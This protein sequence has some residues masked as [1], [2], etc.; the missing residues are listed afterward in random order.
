MY[1]IL[2]LFTLSSYASVY[3]VTGNT[4]EFSSPAF[5]LS[6]LVKEYASAQK[7]NVVFDSDFR[8]TKFTMV[9]PRSFE[10]SALE[11]YISAMLSQSGYGF[12]ILPETQTLSIFNSRDVR[13][14]ITATF[15]D[16]EK[17]P[18]TYEHVQFMYELKHIPS[19][20]LARNLRP[21]MGRYARIIE[22]TNS[23]FISDTGKNV[24]RVMKLVKELDTSEYINSA[25]EVKLLNEKNLKTIK[26]QKS[27]LSILND[28]NII[29]LVLFSLIGTIIGFGLRGYSM[30]RI[31]GG[32]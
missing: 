2:L 26:T 28:N 8:D 29:F 1:L 32:W 21:M 3:D 13:Y 30:K 27:F 16:L 18:D 7:L 31:E 19:A 20:E 5:M 14:L 23:L 10:K 17:V 22:H 11:N 6:E 25:E 15:K 12:R 24:H 9:G 4:V